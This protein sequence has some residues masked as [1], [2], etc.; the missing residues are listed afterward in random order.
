MHRHSYTRAATHMH[1]H[2]YIFK[3]DI[4]EIQSS[5]T[6][7]ISSFSRALPSVEQI[8]HCLNINRTF[9][10]RLHIPPILQ[11]WRLHSNYLCSTPESSLIITESPPWWSLVFTESPPWWSLV[12]TEDPPWWSWRVLPGDQE[13]LFHHYIVLCLLIY[14]LSIPKS[15]PHT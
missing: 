7:Q 3:W 10:K 13:R 14:M 2:T 11:C 9:Q 8:P 15:D 12:I 6:Y 1:V 5:D 4:S